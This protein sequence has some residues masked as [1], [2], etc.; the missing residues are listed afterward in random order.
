VRSL[1]Q[2]SSAQ[3]AALTQLPESTRA[4][5]EAKGRLYGAIK[6]INNAGHALHDGD[7]AKAAKYTLKEL[8]LKRGGGKAKPDAGGETGTTATTK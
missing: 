6:D 8:Y 2:S 4:F 7:L 1:E 5:C 3:D